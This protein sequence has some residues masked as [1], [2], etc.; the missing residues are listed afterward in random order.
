MALS[1][2]LILL[3]LRQHQPVQL[4]KYAIT[5]LFFAICFN[6]T[7]QITEW[8]GQF[9]SASNSGFVSD[10]KSTAIRN[11]D[12][13]NVYIAGTFS[14][15]S[16]DFD[17][18]LGTYFLEP[19]FS[20]AAFVC[21]LDPSGSLIW[22]K[23]FG[24]SSSIKVNSI[25]VDG[26][27]AVYIVG[28]FFF[29]IDLDPGPGVFELS[30]NGGADLY[31]SKLDS[32]GEFEWA[33]STGG[34]AVDQAFDVVTDNDNN[35]YV[36]GSF[37]YGDFDP[38]PGT[39]IQ[40]PIETSGFIVKYDEN[41]NHLN[42]GM[43]EA[44][45]ESSASHCIGID[46]TGV[47]YVAGVL[48]GSVDVDPGPGTNVLTN[49]DTNGSVYVVKIDTDLSLIW[50][51]KFNALFAY[52]IK[53]DNLGNPIIAGEFLGTVDFDPGP[54]VYTLVGPTSSL[55]KNTFISKLN[56]NGDFLWARQYPNTTTTNADQGIY[57]ATDI[58]AN[59]YVMGSF[60]DTIDLDPGTGTANFVSDGGVDMYISQLDSSGAM[61]W[62]GTIGGT[63][64]DYAAGLCVT[65][66]FK[67]YHTGVFTDTVD[68]DPTTAVTT[69]TSPVNYDTYVQITDHFDDVATTLPETSVEPGVRVL[70]NPTTGSVKIQFSEFAPELLTVT[71]VTGKIVTEQR[72]NGEKQIELVLEIPPGVYFL[73]LRGGEDLVVRRMIKQ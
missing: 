43:F 69:L 63:G 14:I 5:L 50:A 52:D 11:D 49:T 4:M 16:A 51:K 35:V 36:V 21:K 15:D 25:A 73:V 66:S 67:M 39:V 17:P 18:G 9:S 1:T 47:L 3:F 8:I 34:S 57:L 72:L 13:G 61:L 71:D 42:S 46:P 65:D 41:G 28:S 32:N 54:G 26:T 7:A 59:I 55:E 29:T 22:V 48:R 31:I 19:D 53:L 60:F 27:G 38:G 45:G 24:G 12:L 70:P 40:N 68:V 62:G 58:N 64:H 30:V 20:V 2:K 33:M 23:R 37:D 10:V 6:G 56:P 44:F